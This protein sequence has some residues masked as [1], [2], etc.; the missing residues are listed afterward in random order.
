MALT[1]NFG[2]QYYAASCGI[3]TTG[4]GELSSNNR[5]GYYFLSGSDYIFW[6]QSTLYAPVTSNK[7]TNYYF[8]K[9]AVPSDAGLVLSANNGTK[10]DYLSALNCIT[11]CQ[12]IPPTFKI[13]L[14]SN[15]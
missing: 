14:S 5:A 11:W 13:S 10:Y 1:D 12:V 3:A 4:T 2:T 9:C 8:Y 6:G 15:K 7:D